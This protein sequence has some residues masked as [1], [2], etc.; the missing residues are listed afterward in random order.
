MLHRLPFSPANYNQ[1]DHFLLY[2][3]EL[4]ELESSINN[5][6]QNSTMVE[7][8]SGASTI[9]WLEIIKSDCKLI[10]IEHN[11]EWYNK[12]NDYIKSRPDFYC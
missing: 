9:R 8:G 11:Q 3:E 6:S 12:V 2:D 5:L 1:I 10:S 4:Q 7:W